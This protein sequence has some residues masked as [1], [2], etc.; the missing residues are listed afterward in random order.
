MNHLAFLAC[1]KSPLPYWRTSDS[2][3][4]PAQ[5]DCSMA[6]PYIQSRCEM[7]ILIWRN[8]TSGRS[9]KH[10]L[11]WQLGGLRTTILTEQSSSN[12]KY[13]IT[14][15]RFPTVLKIVLAINIYWN[16]H[17][18]YSHLIGLV[19][20]CTNNE[21]DWSIWQNHYNSLWIEW[22]VTNGK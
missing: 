13:G 15:E 4:P 12:G 9:F 11:Y 3:I 22:T 5:V 2:C 21:C 19:C 10:R 6:P 17:D 7:P 1:C 16:K 8:V 18:Q 20:F 14:K